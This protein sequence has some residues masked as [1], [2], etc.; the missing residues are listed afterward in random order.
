M[1]NLKHMQMELSVISVHLNVIDQKLVRYS[2]V[3]TYWRENGHNRT[4]DELC[5][6]FKKQ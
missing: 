3:I 4:V 5:T 2:E 1:Q 6:G